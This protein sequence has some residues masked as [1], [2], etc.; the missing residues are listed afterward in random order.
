MPTNCHFQIAIMTLCL[1]MHKIHR[2]VADKTADKLILRQIIDG[3]RLITLL[4]RAI[5]YDR[6]TITHAK[7]FNLVVGDIDRRRTQFGHQGF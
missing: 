4:D 5:S 7:S 1:S 3:R 6:D 2:W